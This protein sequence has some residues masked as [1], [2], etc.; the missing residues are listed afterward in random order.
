MENWLSICF[1]PMYVHLHKGAY[2]QYQ[3][4]LFRVGRAATSLGQEVIFYCGKTRG[5]VQMRITH[6]NLSN[7]ASMFALVQQTYLAKK[8][9]VKSMPISTLDNLSLQ[10]KIGWRA[11]EKLPFFQHASSSAKISMESP[12]PR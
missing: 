5:R 9:L 6:R 4:I 3:Q 7:N 12:R 11:A 2:V 8:N 1:V 10:H